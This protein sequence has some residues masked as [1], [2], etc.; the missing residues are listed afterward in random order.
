MLIGQKAF[1]RSQRLVVPLGALAIAVRIAGAQ[2]AR[3]PIAIAERATHTL[4][5][6]GSA[7]FLAA[8]DSEAWVT[9]RGRIEQ[10]RV[11][12]PAPVATVAI[13]R[14][15]GGMESAF[16]A[17]WVVDCS[18]RTLVRVRRDS[19]TIEA[20]I[21]TGVADR[22]GELS[23]AAGA[24]SIWLLTDSTGVLSRVDPVTNTVVARIQVK[25]RSYAAVFGFGSVWITNTGARGDTMPGSVQRI[26]P[27]TN[28]V[29]ATIGVGPVP[30]FLAA[31]AGGVWTLN[32]RDG[33]VSRIDPATN[34]LAA[35][36]AAGAAGGGGDIATGA[37][38]V[39]VRA[40]RLLLQT[41]D[42][43]TNRVEMQFGPPSGSGAVRVA[44]NT[45]W[46]T[47]HDIQTVW[48]LKW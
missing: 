30:R 18:N 40:T 16:G 28:S 42:P 20:V 33:T 6:P 8:A 14:P 23:I 7:D 4:L 9:N 15:C 12:S 29:T 27:A 3:A 37:G 46:V 21:P 11:G 10:L 19:A 38:R 24:G 5:I 44:G 41:I 39:W 45:V 48:I 25:P 43:A 17:V 26:D 31:G 36:I 47:A 34:T 1:A 2:A 13:A 32:Q 22:S 35:T